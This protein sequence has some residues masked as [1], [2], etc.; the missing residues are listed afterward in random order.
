MTPGTWPRFRFAQRAFGSSPWLLA[1][2]LLDVTLSGQGWKLA[3]PARNASA[4]SSEEQAE[5][6]VLLGLPKARQNAQGDARER[7]LL[8]RCAFLGPLPPLDLDVVKGTPR[9]DVL[10]A[11]RRLDGAC[12]AHG[13]GRPA[14]RDTGGR[15]LHG[16]QVAPKGLEAVDLLRAVGRLIAE[17]IA[18][19]AGVPLIS[20][21]REREGRPPIVLD[22]S[23]FEKD[24]TGRAG[25]WR[26]VGAARPDGRKKTPIDLEPAE[27]FGW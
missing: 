14:W 11:A 21:Y 7:E 4:L 10:A 6:L 16:D 3:G 23:L 18:P 15:G 2:A 9:A 1:P 17:K 8:A 19:A 22:D 24:A 27:T 12:V 25:V 26:L 5:L 20:S 13:W